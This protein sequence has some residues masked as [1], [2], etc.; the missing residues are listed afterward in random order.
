MIRGLSEKYSIRPSEIIDVYDD[1]DYS[2]KIIL[3]YFVSIVKSELGSK[4][5]SI[6]D[7]NEELM[8]MQN[9]KMNNWR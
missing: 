9:K 2:E 7:L 3:D 6:E 1:L 5:K 8:K 4:T